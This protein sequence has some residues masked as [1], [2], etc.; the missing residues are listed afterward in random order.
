MAKKRKPKTEPK[1]T[2]RVM[3]KFWCDVEKDEEREVLNL[4]AYLKSIRKFAPTVRLGIRIICQLMEGK[5]DLLL[6]NFPWIETTILEM[7]G[8]SS[9]EMEQFQAMMLAQMEHLVASGSTGQS[10]PT[11]SHIDDEI[12][13]EDDDTS[14]VDNF[15]EF[16]F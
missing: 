10:G 11:S 15:L 13:V 1:P 5:L 8:R 12:T 7:H 2:Y 6:E 16:T 4:I 9:R 3:E 14:A